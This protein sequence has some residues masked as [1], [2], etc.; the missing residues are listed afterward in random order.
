[1]LIIQR[2]HITMLR[3]RFQ[4][5]TTLM[6]RLCNEL[7]RKRTI[8]LKT[9]SPRGKFSFLLPLQVTCLYSSANFESNVADN[10]FFHLCQHCRLGCNLPSTDTT[11]HV[12][13]RTQGALAELGKPTSN[14][15]F[16]MLA[17]WGKQPQ[18]KQIH[19]HRHHL[20]YHELLIF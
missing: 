9:F 2:R 16:Y 18:Q 17:S 3:T 20:L 7:K 1:M 4:H 13:S 19:Y 8:L 6:N 15:L 14:I 11:L 5:K 12:S 10:F